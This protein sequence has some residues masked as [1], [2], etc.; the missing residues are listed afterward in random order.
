MKIIAFHHL[1]ITILLHKVSRGFIKNQG[2]QIL[3]TA[4]WLAFH[5]HLAVF[6]LC[7]GSQHSAGWSLIWYIHIYI[8]VFLYFHNFIYI[9]LEYRKDD[10]YIFIYF[11]FHIE[12]FTAEFNF[13]LFFYLPCASQSPRRYRISPA[14]EATLAFKGQPSPREPAKIELAMKML[15]IIVAFFYFSFLFYFWYFNRYFTFSFISH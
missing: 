9:L 13:Y 15:D 10:I 11:W 2:H 1:I 8:V 3:H 12:L 14:S 4:A 5:S 7:K 6:I